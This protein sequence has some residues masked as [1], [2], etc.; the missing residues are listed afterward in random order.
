MRKGLLIK[1]AS[2][3]EIIVGAALVLALDLLSRLL[4]AEAPQ[5]VGGLLGRVGDCALRLWRWRS[6]LH[7][8]GPER[9]W[10]IGAIY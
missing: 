4:F 2:W 5:G 9:R 7:A 6:A 3:L 1:V 10:G 8:G